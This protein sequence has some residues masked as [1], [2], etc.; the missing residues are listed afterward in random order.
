M[1]PVRAFADRRFKARHL[2]VLGALCKTYDSETGGALVS[3][4]K[5]ADPRRR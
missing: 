3:Q 4:G 5:I 1:M 2:R